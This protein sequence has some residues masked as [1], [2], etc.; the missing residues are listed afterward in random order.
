MENNSNIEEYLFIDDINDLFILKQATTTSWGLKFSNNNKVDENSI[1]IFALVSNDFKKMVFNKNDLKMIKKL[2]ELIRIYFSNLYVNLICNQK[3]TK[4]K[5]FSK[6]SATSALNKLIT[7]K[8]NITQHQLNQFVISDF[9]VNVD[10]FDKVYKLEF[11]NNNNDNN[12]K[13]QMKS[14]TYINKQPSGFTRM[15]INNNQP[16]SNNM[17]NNNYQTYINNKNNKFNNNNNNLNF[18]MNNP[19]FNN[20]NQ[21][22]QGNSMNFMNL[23]QMN[24]INQMLF[25]NNQ[26]LLNNIQLNYQLMN[27]FNSNNKFQNNMQNFNKNSFQNNMPNNFSFN[28]NNNQMQQNIQNNFK[29]VNQNKSLE[30]II[31]YND[32]IEKTAQKYFKSSFYE[33][34]EN[35]LFSQKGLNNVGLTCYM[36]STLQCLLHIP[37][38]SF[39]FLN[40][41]DKFKIANEKII[42]KTESKGRISAEYSVIV[43][44]IFY[45]SVDFFGRNSCSPKKFN[46][47]IS[48]LNPQFSKYESN[49]AKDLIIYLLQE[50]HEELNYFG[51]EKLK[52][53]PKCNQLSEANAFNFFYEVNSKLNFSII[54][55]LFWGIVK[56]TTICSICHNYLF[57][58]QY[59]QYL[60]FPLY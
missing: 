41:Y 46:D 54:S 44:E 48:K 23:Q 21:M 8:L 11:G 14:K 13:S 34:L 18:N 60:S 24:E 45:G 53:I 9:N 20:M 56:Q 28:N 36:N 49:D 29:N 52:K 33:G 10:N 57:N 17:L 25:R 32:E 7:E 50:M 12:I 39:Y 30:N 42:K 47:V 55:Y 40:I 38:L 19:S 3:D 31:N 2:Y 22:K 1:Y 51:G 43:N 4:D 15:M 26:M 37:E 27:Q 5:I 35:G 58:F 59:Y 6:I 16:N